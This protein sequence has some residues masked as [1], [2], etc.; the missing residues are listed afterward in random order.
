[1]IR[2]EQPRPA[3]KHNTQVPGIRLQDALAVAGEAANGIAEGQAFTAFA[4]GKEDL[5][6]QGFGDHRVS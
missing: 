2:G 3:P 1:M 5:A 4:T 6:E